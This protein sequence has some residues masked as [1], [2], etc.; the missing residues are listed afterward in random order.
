MACVYKCQRHVFSMPHLSANTPA[1]INYAKSQFPPSK[2]LYVHPYRTDSSEPVPS[3]SL[4][5]F[6][7]WSMASARILAS[8]VQH[9]QEFPDG[10]N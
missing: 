1:A 3:P 6:T 10:E 2:S 4:A 5:T 8:S 9:T 7:A